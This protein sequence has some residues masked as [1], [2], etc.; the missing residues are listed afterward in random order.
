MSHH[1]RLVTAE[2]VSHVILVSYVENVLQVEFQYVC[3]L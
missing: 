1:H 3:V 2:N